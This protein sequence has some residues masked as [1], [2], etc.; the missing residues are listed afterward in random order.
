MDPDVVCR[1]SSSERFTKG[2]RTTSSADE[3]NEAM[4]YYILNDKWHD[5]LKPTYL[6]KGAFG[7]VSKLGRGVIG[8]PANKCRYIVKVQQARDESGP[9]KGDALSED[10]IYWEKE[11]TIHRWLTATRHTWRYFLDPDFDSTGRIRDTNKRIKAMFLDA[12][13]KTMSE[14]KNAA[15]IE[16]IK[17]KRISHAENYI[18][19]LA[20]EFVP[21]FQYALIFNPNASTDATMRTKSAA[22]FIFMAAPQET[23]DGATIHSAT[24][25]ALNDLIHKEPKLITKPS[26]GLFSFLSEPVSEVEPTNSVDWQF[27]LFALPDLN[28]TKAIYNFVCQPYEALSTIHRAGVLHLDIKPDNLLWQFVTVEKEVGGVKTNYILP[29][30]FQFIDFG[31]AEICNINPAADRAART[32]FYGYY[33]K[34]PL[35]AFTYGSIPGSM[36]FKYPQDQAPRVMDG[37]LMRFTAQTICDFYSLHKCLDQLIDSMFRSDQLKRVLHEINN[38]FYGWVDYYRDKTTGRLKQDMD[39]SMPTTKHEMWITLTKACMKEF[40]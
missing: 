21:M 29:F 12:P 11:T 31:L 2:G 1:I 17:D 10:L 35:E 8:N 32:D 33:F 20:K 14:S 40:K 15:L 34:R 3:A 30:K 13:E 37:T 23:I 7:S 5:S 19:N 24:G 38:T 26:S 36:A 4:T 27:R 16:E 28:F 6:G 18:P 25:K 9:K 22:N 39:F